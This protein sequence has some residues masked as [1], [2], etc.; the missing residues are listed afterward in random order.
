M[1]MHK[2]NYQ[3]IKYEKK[4]QINASVYLI[5][6]LLVHFF[7]SSFHHPNLSGVILLL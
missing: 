7:I 6:V 5:T 3:E 2:I 4:Q 1:H